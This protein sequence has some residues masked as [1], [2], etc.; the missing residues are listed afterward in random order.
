MAGQKEYR[1]GACWFVEV[2]CLGFGSSRLKLS[3]K[4]E[5][6]S[7]DFQPP[8]YILFALKCLEN[9]GWVHY[10]S[11]RHPLILRKSQKERVSPANK[12]PEPSSGPCP[13]CSDAV[14]ESLLVCPRCETYV[15]SLPTFMRELNDRIDP[16]SGRFVVVSRFVFPVTV[17]IADD[18]LAFITL[19]RHV[20]D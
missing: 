9:L 19:P 12:R 14:P 16:S 1:V 8:K 13:K 11:R 4:T 17:P 3:S 7:A 15:G 6:G 20:D 10:R 18:R 5:V 2:A